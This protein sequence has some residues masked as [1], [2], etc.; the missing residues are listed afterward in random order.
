MNE[1]KLKEILEEVCMEE[2]SISEDAPVHLFSLRHKKKIRHILSQSNSVSKPNIKIKLNRRIIRILIVA[3]FLRLLTI[4]GAAYVISTFI[5]KEYSDNTQIF[6]G[7][8][9]EA[10]ET[11]EQVYYLT[12][13]PEGYS[14]T[15][16]FSDLYIM[17]VVYQYGNDVN[18]TITFTQTVKKEYDQHFNTEGYSIETI[19]INGC[20]CLF[21]DWSDGDFVMCE[22]VWD[23]GDYILT[24][25]GNL[26]KSELINLAK[27]A[28]LL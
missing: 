5:K 18:N 12:Q 27:S 23:N 19:D 11:I 21:I 17:T 2:Y 7:D 9:F 13:L 28:K 1:Y 15:E 10:P 4:S 8:F 26:S 25:D 22:A 3:I 16:R 24:L 6:A 20:D 14:E